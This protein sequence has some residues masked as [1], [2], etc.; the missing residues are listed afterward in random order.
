MKKSIILGLMLSALTLTNCTKNE[1]FTVA[2]EV[3][4]PFEIV[5]NVD[6]RTTNDGLNTA[7]AA[8]DAINLFHAVAEGTEYLS[9]GSFTIA[10]EDVAAGRFTGTL[11]GSLTEA[12]YD[13][14]AI[15][16]YSEYITTPASTSSGYTIIGHDNRYSL[17][18]NGNNSTAHLAGTACPLVGVSKGVAATSVPSLEMHHVS[19]VVKFVVKNSL[20]EAIT[21]SKITLESD[22]HNIIGS[23]YVD[24]TEYPSV[25][26]TNALPA[27]TAI[28]DVQNGE[29]IA[30]GSTASFYLPIKP[31][32]MEVGDNLTV[33]VTAESVT[34]VGTD[35][36]TLE[37]SSDISFIAGNIKTLNV[38]YDTAIIPAPDETWS[39]ITH[40]TQIVEG[41]YV[42]VTKSYDGTFN[43]MANTT[44]S[45]NPLSVETTLFDGATESVTTNKVTAD[46]RWTF[47]G[48]YDALTITN[49]ENKYLYSINEN[50]GV[51]V[52]T[53]SDTWAASLNTSVGGAAIALKDS[54]CSRY[55]TSYKT[56]AKNDWRAYTNLYDYSTSASHPQSGAVYL[57]YCGEAVRKPFITASNPSI[58][59]AVGATITIP[60]TVTH[61]TAGKSLTA[62]SSE[63]WATVGTI[64]GETISVTVAAN[65]GSDA[66]EATLTLSYEN[67]V[68]SVELTINQESATSLKYAL[69]S[70]DVAAI[71]TQKGST[72]YANWSY[73]ATDGSSWSGYSASNTGLLQLG[74]NTETTKAAA[75][76]YILLPALSNGK[77]AT[78]I[79]IIPDASTSNNRVLIA[80]PSTYQYNGESDTDTKNMAYAI[81]E[82]TV[83][84]STDPLTIDLTGIETTEQIKVRAVGGAVYI[85]EITLVYE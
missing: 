49:P 2:P 19:S 60:Y 20:S 77:K 27:K 4:T 10:S 56:D 40:P 79:T 1:E 68:E 53:T 78:K 34:C 75:N 6:T 22:N 8:D 29:A 48:T 55:L 85:T 80:V 16:P 73:T 15:Y 50:Q 25:S 38:N 57:Y 14:Y 69:T 62:T 28:L 45:A 59:A 33:T 65:S 46:M 63:T 11:N 82:N 41:T 71:H 12:N 30:A 83:K 36:S 42:I 58:V 72:S 44:T 64:D 61:P 76:S 81:S 9:D 3:S 32:A 47:A 17:V 13:W 70:A 31:C 66:R 39:L 24:F 18:Q 43:Y 52:N 35:T 84:S 54:N 74:W 23:Y 21:V 7:W 67:A 37:L 5:A 26:F 51:R